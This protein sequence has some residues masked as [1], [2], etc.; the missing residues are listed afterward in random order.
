MPDTL[1][2]VGTYQLPVRTP[3]TILDEQLKSLQEFYGGQE[4][5]LKGIPM[6]NT[7]SAG[8][9]KSA[10]IFGLRFSAYNT[11]DWSPTSTTG[12]AKVI[13]TY[14]IQLS[15]DLGYTSKTISGTKAQGIN[16]GGSIAA[17]MLG[18]YNATIA[19]E[20]Y[21]L[22]ISTVDSLTD[23]SGN[24]T[25]YGLYINTC[26]GSTKSGGGV[27]TS[28]GLYEANGRDNAMGNLY[29]VADNTYYL[30]KNSITSP[31]GWKG[32]CLKDTTNGNYYKIESINGVLTA[33]QIV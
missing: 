32:V 8:G 4:K 18:T 26:A 1:P 5:L 21:G 28:W 23:A 15:A 29:P 7:Q 13:T 16:Y 20:N 25:S 6:T 31:L 17:S 12:S 11:L 33:T 27:I 14:G 24:I 10:D 3:Y 9:V 30:G 2:E 22:K 19:G